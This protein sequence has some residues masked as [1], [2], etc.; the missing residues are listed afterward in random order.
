M[1]A[2]RNAQERAELERRRCTD[3][4]VTVFFDTP[5]QL[6]QG[7]DALASD[8]QVLLVRVGDEKQRLREHDACAALQAMWRKDR[9]MKKFQVQVYHYRR[10]LASIRI[11][12]AY[13]VAASPTPPSCTTRPGCK[14]HSCQCNVLH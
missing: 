14:Y 9:A 6:V 1:A 10:E 11:Q 12:C 5:Q 13:S 2:G 7:L 3:D 8:P 4:T